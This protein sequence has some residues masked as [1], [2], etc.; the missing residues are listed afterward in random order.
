MKIMCFVTAVGRAYDSC[1]MILLSSHETCA[2]SSGIMVT[3]FI[4][5]RTY[6]PQFSY[7]CRVMGP[8]LNQG[9]TK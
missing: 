9:A 4:M 8:N 5:L 2:L 6:G 7:M 3:I 1:W